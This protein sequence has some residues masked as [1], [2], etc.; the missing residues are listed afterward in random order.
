VDSSSAGPEP[1]APEPPLTETG[2]RLIPGAHPDSIVEA[3]H[4]C[5]YQ[6]AAGLA[7]GRTILDAGCG[8]GYG[9]AMLA[10]AGA[11][12]VIAID[13]DPEALAWGRRTYG[14]LLAFEEADLHALP[15]PART[16]DVVVCFE[17]LEEVIDAQ[18]VL[19]EMRRVL[20]DDGVLV[21]SSPNRGRSIPAD[22]DEA[23]PPAGGRSS[24]ELELE[25]G[26]HFAHVR[27]LRQS[28]HL[29][30]VIA[31]DEVVSAEGP[32][33]AAQAELRR[34]TPGVPGEEIDAVVLAS[35]RPL[36][37]V[38]PAA[39]LTEGQS[40]AAWMRSAVSWREAA[41]TAESEMRRAEIEAQHALSERDRALEE[42][43]MMRLRQRRRFRR[44]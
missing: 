12:R 28:M 6:L 35:E 33:V 10:R 20:R 32:E 38:A 11:E 2:E 17:V 30:A 34:L 39:M 15:H 25:L 13:I 31:A 22:R 44:D 37:E 40:M 43:E 24:H 26:A 36:P 19:S 14:G 8:T 5:R 27:V 9:A 3:L 16:F 42:R 4:L 23:A 18:R 29:A 41:L 1:P 21:V 7:A